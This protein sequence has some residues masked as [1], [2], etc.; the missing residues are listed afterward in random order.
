MNIRPVAAKFL[1]A[2][3]HTSIWET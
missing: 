2:E 3:G 1:H